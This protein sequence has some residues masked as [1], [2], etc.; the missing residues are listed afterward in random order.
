MDKQWI[1]TA[2]RLPK[3]RTIVEGK[4]LNGVVQLLYRS[5]DRWYSTP[6]LFMYVHYKPVLWRLLKKKKSSRPRVTRS[7]RIIRELFPMEYSL[8]PK[9]KAVPEKPRS[10]QLEREIAEAMRK[11]LERC[12]AEFMP[13]QGFRSIDEIC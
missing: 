1:E 3:Q 2:S 6:D 8:E 10:A 11:N 5:G 9:E 13:R 12:F 4:D 7:R